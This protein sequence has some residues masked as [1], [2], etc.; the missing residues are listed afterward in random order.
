MNARV[1]TSL[2]IAY[3]ATSGLLWCIVYVYNNA[4]DYKDLL[5]ALPIPVS[6]ESDERESYERKAGVLVGRALGRYPSR[7]Q[8]S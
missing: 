6:S 2:G 7:E 4:F 3:R 1:S 8:T 5:Y